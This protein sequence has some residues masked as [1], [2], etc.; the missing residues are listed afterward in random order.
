MGN[1]AHL[2][3]LQGH[4]ALY[5]RYGESQTGNAPI[6]PAMRKKQHLSEMWGS[7]DW[8][9]REEHCRCG[10]VQRESMDTL[11]LIQVVFIVAGSAFS[12]NQMSYQ[13][14]QINQI[15]SNQI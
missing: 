2:I 8:G 9:Q 1:R 6:N 3:R 11:N 14:N 15:K 7:G 4:P 10:L 13:T 12:T 5:M